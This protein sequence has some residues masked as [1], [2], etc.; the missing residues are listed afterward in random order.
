[1]GNESSVQLPPNK[2]A[3]HVLYRFDVDMGAVSGGELDVELLFH[4]EFGEV[5]PFPLSQITSNDHRTMEC[6]RQ[7]VG[8][9]KF[10]I[11]IAHRKNKALPS[12]CLKDCVFTLSKPD[13]VFVA[14]FHHC[15]SY[16]DRPSS[17]SPTRRVESPMG[18]TTKGE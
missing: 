7:D 16:H 2:N 17:P 15:D 13:E 18:K 4:C 1:M 12:W 6:W 10:C 14:K 11:L 8:G 3:M 9:A 5:G